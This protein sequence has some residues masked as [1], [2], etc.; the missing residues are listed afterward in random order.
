MIAEI[1]TSESV[2]G[3][4]EGIAIWQ[5]MNFARQQLKGSAFP[6]VK[7]IMRIRRLLKLND[8]RDLSQLPTAAQN[9][10]A[11]KVMTI[12]SSKGLE[13]PVVHLSGVNKDTLPGSYRRTK[14]PPPEEY[15]CWW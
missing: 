2:G 14:C 6:I 15:G 1:A 4:A 12:H 10:D 5:F 3:K 7:M 13:F 11:V 8:D 9:I